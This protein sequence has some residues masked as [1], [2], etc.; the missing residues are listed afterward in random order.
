MVKRNPVSLC[1]DT[2][3]RWDENDPNKEKHRKDIEE[4]TDLL[5][6]K[7]VKNCAEKIESIV[8]KNPKKV[9][10]VFKEHYFF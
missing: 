1:S 10:I 8:G 3:T 2:Y 9:K 5:H 4:A 6:T 7:I